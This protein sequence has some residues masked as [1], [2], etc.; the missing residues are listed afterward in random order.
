MSTENA[1]SLSLRTAAQVSAKAPGHCPVHAPKRHQSLCN[2]R[3]Q[4]PWFALPCRVIL[5]VAERGCPLCAGAPDTT[6]VVKACKPACHFH[7][8]ISCNIALACLFD[9]SDSPRRFLSQ[10]GFL[11]SGHYFLQTFQQHTTWRTSGSK[12]EFTQCSKV[13]RSTATRPA[14]E[15][16]WPSCSRRS[17]RPRG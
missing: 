9:A 16:A 10:H 14:G 13:E 2:M 5:R 6:C 3:A 17:A 7:G 4:L 1:R 11:T 15:C 8:S 12:Q